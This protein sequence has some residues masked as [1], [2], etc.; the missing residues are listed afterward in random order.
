MNGEKIL[1]KH[2]VL[3]KSEEKK[4]GSDFFIIME[5]YTL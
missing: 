4:W 2:T 5:D 3:S 1:I